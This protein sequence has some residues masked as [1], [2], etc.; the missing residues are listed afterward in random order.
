MRI[1][2]LSQ[3]LAVAVANAFTEFSVT[4]PKPVEDKNIHEV[5]DNIS[6]ESVAGTPQPTNTYDLD[7]EKGSDDSRENSSVKATP[8]K[9]I[10]Y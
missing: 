10:I 2:K 7:T 6:F 4:D 1:Q 3:Q 8:Q 9:T 5:T